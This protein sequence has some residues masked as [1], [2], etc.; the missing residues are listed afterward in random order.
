[1]DDATGGTGSEDTG[2]FSFNFSGGGDSGNDTRSA[3]VGDA[4]GSIEP[5]NPG[6]GIRDA[7]G[8]EF[9]P[10]QHIGADRF[11]RDGSFKRKRGRKSGKPNTASVGKRK[12]SPGAASVASIT[13]ALEGIHLTLAFAFKTPEIALEDDE[14]KPLA[15][16]IAEVA[17]H[18]DIP[19]IAPETVAWISLAVTA[20]RIYGPKAMLIRER[21][22]AEKAQRVGKG[23]VVHF[24][25]APQHQEFDGAS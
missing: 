3:D 24:P 6:S 21:I 14:S 23:E 5:G 25:F 1:M 13:N 9:D 16:A 22:R 8:T 17:K 7:T 12:N 18:Y 11:N 2:A 15:E 20:G 4:F 10:A 19:V